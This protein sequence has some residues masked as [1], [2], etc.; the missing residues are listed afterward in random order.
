MYGSVFYFSFQ[1]PVNLVFVKIQ[2]VE[3]VLAVSN[4]NNSAT[5]EVGYMSK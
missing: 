4:R 1:L 2:R 5:N 3:F